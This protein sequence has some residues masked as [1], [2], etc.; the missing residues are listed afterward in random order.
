MGKSRRSDGQHSIANSWSVG[1][2]LLRGRVSLKLPL[3]LSADMMDLK[4]DF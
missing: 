1:L 3:A 2:I 4:G